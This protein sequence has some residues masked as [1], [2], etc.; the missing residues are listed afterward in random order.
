MMKIYFET[1]K[2]QYTTEEIVRRLNKHEIFVAIKPLLGDLIRYI[3]VGNQ[4]ACRDVSLSTF[5]II[6]D[7]KYKRQFDISDFNTY[8]MFT[9]DYEAMKSEEKWYNET[10]HPLTETKQEIPEWLQRERVAHWSRV[11][12]T[13]ASLGKKEDVCINWA[14]SGVEEFD[15]RFLTQKETK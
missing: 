3:S 9:S 10:L 8:F 14:N 2:K 1:M 5:T 15:K 7:L 4:Y 12:A 11:F 13:H 6:D